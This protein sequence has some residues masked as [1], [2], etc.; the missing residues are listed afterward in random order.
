MVR[1]IAISATF[2]LA[3]GFA[4]LTMDRMLLDYNEQGVYFDG[5]TTYDLD[6][7]FAYK[8]ISLFFLILGIITAI[9]WTK[10]TTKGK[11]MK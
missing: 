11:G 2:V 7:V 1:T 8:M 9:V 3:I 6:A 4:L 5:A 10:P